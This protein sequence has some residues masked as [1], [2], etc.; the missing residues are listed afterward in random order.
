MT[1][2]TNKNFKEFQEVTFKD[3]RAVPLEK[4]N[5]KK[6]T[7]NKKMSV[8]RAL[9]KAGGVLLMILKHDFWQK[10]KI[11]FLVVGSV[12]FGLL[13]GMKLA[14][15]RCVPEEIEAESVPNY[16]SETEKL[17]DLAG[18]LTNLPAEEPYVITLQNINEL[19]DSEFFMDA[20]DGDRVLIF[21]EAR[22]AVIYREAE[23]RVIVEGPIDLEMTE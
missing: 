19:K 1:D 20:A 11:V 7:K 2:G 23:H 4:K 18:Q 15:S 14:G 13:L 22:R 6:R 17:L 3:G 9:G 21:P 10:Y 5:K 16:I 12:G 8:K